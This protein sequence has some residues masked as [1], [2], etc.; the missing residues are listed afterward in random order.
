M[1]QYPE[2]ALHIHQGT[3]TQIAEMAADGTVDFAIATEGMEQFGHLIMM[4]M[5]PL[6]PLRC[7]T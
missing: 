3:P 4:P 7:G 1:Q 5:L 2:V 6:E